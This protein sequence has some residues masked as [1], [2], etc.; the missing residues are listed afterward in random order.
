MNNMNRRTFVKGVLATS[1]IASIPINLSANSKISARKKT[2][3]LSGNTFNL[4]IEKIAVNVTGNPSIAKTVNG[5]LSGPTLRWKEGDTVT[6]N[7]TNNLNEDTSI[8][9]HGI[10]L[11]A[12]MDGVPGFS[13][14]NG[15]KP[16]ETFTYKFPILQSGTY[17]YHSHSGFQE[18]EG[19]FGAIIIEPKIKDPY[20]YDREYVISLSDW[21]DEKPSSVY[22]KL[23][24]SASYYNFKQR[25][26]GDFFDEVKEKGFFE[27]FSERKMWN[28]MKMTDRDISDVSG[29]TYTYL[30]NG[31][32]PATG[33]KALFKNGEKIRLRFINS[34][35]MTF[36]DVRIP[37]LKMTVV[38]ADGNNI[39]P[40]TIDEFR[41]GVAETYDVIVEPEVNK[42]YSIFA[43]SIDRSGYALGA[44]TFDEKVIAQTPQM[45]AFPI[46]THADMGMGGTSDNNSE[47]DMST[48]ETQKPTM[49]HSMM[50]HDMSTMNSNQKKEIPITKL[51]ESTGV[52]VDAVAMN[53]QY[54]L[55]DPGVGLR[56]NGRRV[57]TYA[58]LKSLTPTTNDKYPDR[59]IILRLTGN[60]ER[61]MW[62][63]NGI[64]YK[65]A[66]PLEF[67]Y[68][69]RLRITYIND[70]M[71]NHPMHLHGMW[72]DLETGD[73]NYLPRKHTIVV[74]PGSKISFRVN[75]DAKG[76]WA[77]HCHL[78]YHM[79]DMFRKVIV[80]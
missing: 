52:Q 50:G 4:S 51:E 56:N 14:F 59:E 11:P 21:S 26:V 80:S 16:G 40:V 75:V 28:E 38:A 6:I 48:M 10:I 77:Y 63:I 47:H 45:D 69:E 23:K 24:L 62:S 37:G 9:W 32:N 19:V 12:S 67:K 70:T 1:I 18:Q 33:F 46:L 25:T 35:A 60:M 74:Q 3:E 8:H 66:K 78:L 76:S 2:I 61:Y 17:W 36:F 27:A 58:D 42:A 22:R 72:S 53:P 65:D 55:S 54:R 31:E 49:N 57:L 79:T 64:T 7:V 43:Q 29:Y 68:G 34:A 15:I 5:M 30:M 39:Q 41:I 44:L 71:M 13:N 20:E 73:D